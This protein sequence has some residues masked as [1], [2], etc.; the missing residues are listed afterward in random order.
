MKHVRASRGFTLVELLIVIVVIAILAAITVVAYGNVTSKAN[1]SSAQQDASSVAQK[2]KAY[3]AENGSFPSD[4]SAINVNDPSNGHFTYDNYG[5]S[6]CIAATIGSAT[7]QVEADSSV[8]YG[9]CTHLAA[10]IYKRT[11]SASSTAGA[12]YFTHDSTI[13]GQGLFTPPLDYGWGG[14]TAVAGTPGDDFVAEITGYI[15]APTS[16]TYTFTSIADDRGSLYIDNNLVVDGSV[17]TT[18]SSPITGSL[19]MV[20]GQRM[21]FRYEFAEHTGSAVARLQWSYT[22]HT[23]AD[24]PASAFSG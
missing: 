7:Y 18:S 2:L 12:D 17:A 6:F 21:P 4:L 14:G 16:D 24:V 5:D 13:L 10:T 23:A 9:D 15:T 20:A 22:S 19:G 8:T 1:I 3:L 11:G